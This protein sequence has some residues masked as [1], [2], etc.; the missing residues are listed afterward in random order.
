MYKVGVMERCTYTPV[1]YAKLKHSHHQQVLN[2]RAKSAIL[3]IILRVSTTDLC[4]RM[5]FELD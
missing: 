3:K 4:Q 5:I 1:I 2:L